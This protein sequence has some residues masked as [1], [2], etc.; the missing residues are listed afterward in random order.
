M[1]ILKRT[2]TVIA[3][4]SVTL[5]CCI[6][7]AGAYGVESVEE[8]TCLMF[9]QDVSTAILDEVRGGT[10]TA[11]DG[12]PTTVGVILWDE[13]RLPPPPIRNSN[14]DLRVTG[15]MNVFQK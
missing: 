13:P 12:A 4:A 15:E 10:L 1:S 11:V 5:T 9:G 8:N 7:S 6:A 14:V 2:K 3:A